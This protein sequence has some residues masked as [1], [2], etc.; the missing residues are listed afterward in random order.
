MSA[1]A[2]WAR[3][4]IPEILWALFAAVNFAVLSFVHSW[5]TVPFHF[6][7]VSLTLVYGFRVWGIKPTLIVL[8]IVCAVSTVTYGW[9]V[10][11]GPQGIDELTE[12]PLMAAMFV[13]MVWHAQRRQAAIV[14][15]RKAAGREREFV[16]DA[17]HQLK[18]PV[19]LARG[20]ADLIRGERGSESLR[21]DIADLL[22]ELDQIGRVADDMLILAAAEQ[23]GNL[24]LARPTSR[25]SWSPRL[26]A[27]AGPPIGVAGR[28]DHP[29]CAGRRPPAPRRGARR[30]HRQRGAGDPRRRP[31]HDCR[32]RR[33]RDCRDHRR[34]CRR[35]HPGRRAAAGLRPLL[36]HP[37]GP[38][39]P[40][41]HRARPL[42]RQGDRRGARRQ[43]P[44]R[45]AGHRAGVT[46][47]LP[48]LAVDDEIIDAGPSFA[49]P[50]WAH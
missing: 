23:P 10:V 3:N 42:D 37:L 40:A 8:L 33:R 18:T 1:I 46:I 48:G 16:R 28:L 32:E 50:N 25:T 45:S 13:A 31:H 34:R 24:V 43:C 39:A 30:R 41:R 14:E 9:V 12:I 27:G 38:R 11:N 20:F 44:V 7:W 5:E 35:R 19:A 47:R 36:E 49:V 2:S 21:D 6:V 29:G 4:R 15:V 17:S 26:A 22:E